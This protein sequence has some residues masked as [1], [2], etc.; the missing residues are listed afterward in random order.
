MPA[1][2]VSTNGCT[3][4]FANAHVTRTSTPPSSDTVRATASST[5]ARS[6]TSEAEVRRALED[7]ER[8]ALYDAPLVPLFHSVNVT[9]V[10]PGIS[11][12]VLDPLGAPRYDEV[13]VRPGD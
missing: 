4:T 13:E 8:R 7:A 3:L 1:N 12:V 9:L 5:R 10:R 2:G 11:G 6:A